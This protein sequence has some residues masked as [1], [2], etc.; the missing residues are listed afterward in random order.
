M[1]LQ[2]DGSTISSIRG[3]R[4]SGEGQIA[5]EFVIAPGHK[6]ADNRDFATMACFNERFEW[7][8]VEGESAGCDRDGY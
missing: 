8:G 3:R 2:L 1:I 4:M 6:S 5:N 7:L